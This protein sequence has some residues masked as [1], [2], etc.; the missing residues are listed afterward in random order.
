MANHDGTHWRSWSHEARRTTSP[1]NS[2]ITN[3]TFSKCCPWKQSRWRGS[4]LVEANT[5]CKYA[6]FLPRIWTQLSLT[7]SRQVLTLTKVSF[8]YS[9]PSFPGETEQCPLFLKTGASALFCHLTVQLNVMKNDIG[10]QILDFDVIIYC[11]E[12]VK[13]KGLLYLHN[14][15]VTQ[16][17]CFS[18][19]TQ[20]YQQK[21]VIYFPYVRCSALIYS[22]IFFIITCET[23]VRPLVNRLNSTSISHVVLAALAVV[24]K[25]GTWCAYVSDSE[26]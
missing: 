5:N 23:P 10:S 25:Q 26:H 2:K 14:T 9:G 7:R 24:L 19:Y 20:L 17:S 4:T 21:C 8:H 11:K 12:G 15:M 18:Y 13:M 22:L 1:A 16:W 6:Y 3:G